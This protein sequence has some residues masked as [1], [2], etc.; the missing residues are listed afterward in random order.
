M[1]KSTEVDMD[2]ILGT[3]KYD[4]EKTINPLKA[5]LEEY[6]KERNIVYIDYNYY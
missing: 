2:E 5:V 3:I 4:L 1:T 6:N